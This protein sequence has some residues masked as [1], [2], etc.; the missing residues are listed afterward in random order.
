MKK[1]TFVTLAA[2]TVFGVLATTSFV[3]SKD[4]TVVTNEITVETDNFAAAETSDGKFHRDAFLDGSNY[5]G[6]YYGYN[7][8][9]S[10]M[11]YSNDSY[12]TNTNAFYWNTLN[13]FEDVVYSFFGLNSNL[14]TSYT[15]TSDY[16]YN[17]E[18]YAYDGDENVLPNE[19]LVAAASFDYLNG[20]S[21]ATTGYLNSGYEVTLEGTIYSICGGNS[22]SEHPSLASQKV[23]SKEGTFNQ[24][25]K[26]GTKVSK[27]A[28]LKVT[29]AT[30][31]TVSIYA[32]SNGSSS[33]KLG[34]YDVNNKKTVTTEFDLPSK[35]DVKATT[36]IK[37]DVEL[38]A[39]TYI[40]G[41]TE[42]QAIIYG[43]S[44][45]KTDSNNYATF[46][47]SNT[48]YGNSAYKT[49]TEGSKQKVYFAAEIDDVYG[50]I[51]S[52]DNTCVADVVVTLANGK[53]L[54]KSVTRAF[55]SNL[56]SDGA[57]IYDNNGNRI[58]GS[59]SN[60]YYVYYTMSFDYSSF[61]GANIAC[62]FNV[63]LGN[64]II[65]NTFTNYVA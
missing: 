45:E 23:V 11:G 50:D 34:Y 26:T 57:E 28:G 53:Q 44:F 37:F 19:Y 39:G 43:A 31:G 25:L 22:S 62:T 52:S 65:S 36:S 7:Y 51:S 59:K 24:G 42:G 61:V 38:S 9:K 5:F 13:S 17:Y 41:T 55:Y 63:T 2:A 33:R 32:I 10:A 18:G 64:N 3:V 60:T 4:N 15:K 30:P 56:V 54:K 49:V 1:F 20:T 58:F 6:Y 48:T 47:T 40:F 46:N 8:D 21:A 29:L 14:S 12:W 35:N 16:V 27:Q